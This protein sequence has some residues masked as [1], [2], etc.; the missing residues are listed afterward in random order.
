MAEIEGNIQAGNQDPQLHEGGDNLPVLTPAQEVNKINDKLNYYP[1]L[2][3][4]NY[5]RFW[6]KY[7]RKYRK[8]NIKDLAPVI[9]SYHTVCYPDGVL[10][11]WKDAE[12]WHNQWFGYG[13]E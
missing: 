13:P 2:K 8:I 4:K 12:G 5:V 9:I 11:L 10:F 3:G 7:E 1:K 6:D